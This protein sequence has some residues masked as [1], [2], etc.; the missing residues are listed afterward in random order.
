MNDKRFSF[1]HSQN[2]EREVSRLDQAVVSLEELIDTIIQ[3]NIDLRPLVE[4]ASD[5]ARRLQ[6][7]AA[8]L[9][10]MIANTREHAEAALRASN[11]YQAIVDAINDANNYSMIAFDNAM[12]AD[13][14]VGW[15]FS[16]FTIATDVSVLMGVFQPI[17]HFHLF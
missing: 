16:Y 4:E 7:K 17:V 11:A 12:L 6:Q 2:V 3:D 9:D 8:H 15:L 14:M 10:S 13:D 5:H 1:L